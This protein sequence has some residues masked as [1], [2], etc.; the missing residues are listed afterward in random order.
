M[1]HIDWARRKKQVDEAVTG[2]PTREIKESQTGRWR[3]NLKVKKWNFSRRLNQQSLLTNIKY[4]KYIL[5]CGSS[6]YDSIPW[7]V[8]RNT[9]WK[10]TSSNKIPTYY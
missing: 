3:N 7:Y 10:L 6:T 9:F 1:V 5:S 4:S 8:I 2:N